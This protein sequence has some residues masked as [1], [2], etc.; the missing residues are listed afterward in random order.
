MISCDDVKLVFFNSLSFVSVYLFSSFYWPYLVCMKKEITRILH[1]LFTSQ[2]PVVYQWPGPCT[3]YGCFIVVVRKIWFSCDLS[4]NSC[5]SNLSFSF[6]GFK[7]CLLVCWC[8][9]VMW[10]VHEI[11]ITT[12]RHKKLLIWFK[13]NTHLLI[14]SGT[15]SET[16]CHTPLSHTTN[17]PAHTP[18][19]TPSHTPS[20]R[21]SDTP[22]L[23]N[24]PMFIYSTRTPTDLL[25]SMEM[26]V[27]TLL[28][29]LITLSHMPS[30]TPFP[31][32]LYPFRSFD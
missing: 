22:S 23:P 25:I 31:L 30:H 14:H 12:I 24:Y 7:D 2:S 18:S 5:A 11:I 8:L 6:R 9:W 29:P 32:T 28:H 26:L 17:T 15:S 3:V 10:P 21:P 19:N 1:R 13:V 27:A 4:L 20:H 16:S